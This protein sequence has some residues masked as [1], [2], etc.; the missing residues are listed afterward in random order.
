[1]SP[2][3]RALTDDIVAWLPTAEL[4][5][6][7]RPVI[8]LLIR[9][10]DEFIHNHLHHFLPVAHQDVFQ[11]LAERWLTF[12]RPERVAMGA[13]LEAGS[14]PGAGLLPE[15]LDN[16]SSLGSIGT[17]S[18]TV[19]EIAPEETDGLSSLSSGGTS[20]QAGK[21]RMEGEVAEANQEGVHNVEDCHDPSESKTM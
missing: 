14:I 9:A 6:L 11:R 10:D 5:G 21:A 20:G 8:E 17:W 19:A 1:V 12:E 16:V 4:V 15:Q 2:V 3:A 13:L 18:V 7:R